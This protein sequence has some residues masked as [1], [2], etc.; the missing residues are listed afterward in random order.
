MSKYLAFFC[1]ILSLSFSCQSGSSKAKN[2]TA[3]IKT[4]AKVTTLKDTTTPKKII[5]AANRPDKYLHLLS[6]KKVALLV[7][8]SAQAGGKHLLDFLLENNIEVVKVFAPEHGFRGNQDRGKHFASN[9]DKKTG[10]PIIAMYGKN[11]KPKQEQLKGID[12]V[13]FDI[14]DVGVRFFTYISSM[15][16]M[17]EACAE[18]QKEFLV[19][20]RP[21]PLGDYI[22]G[23]IREE[24]YKSFVGMHPIPIV[25]GLTVGELARMINGENWLKA[26]KKCLLT[27]I[28]VK[29]YTHSMHYNLP[30]KPSPNL[31]NM[32]A[33]RLYPSLCFFEATKVSIG[34]GTLSPFQ[35]VGYPDKNFGDFSFVP[36]DIKG[37]QTNPI[38]EG[39]RCYGIDL[40][41]SNPDSIKFTLKYIIDFASKFPQK[42]DLISNASWFNAL[43][44][45]SELQAQ[46]ISGTSESEIKASWAKPLSAYKKMRKSYLLYPDFE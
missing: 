10:T 17:M 46:I 22:D 5:C 41:N 16:Y 8:H 18:A 6:T 44:G 12:V 34:R 2:Q 39:K 26:N 4:V 28:P 32:V 14:Q 42:K 11:R 19:L 35:V 25:H 7:N 40:Q 3:K 24:K 38:Q 27:V 9:I 31:P 30:V 45:N 43:A 1:C 20:D 21:N 33:I 37:M 15:H 29:N 36:K 23:A 13:V